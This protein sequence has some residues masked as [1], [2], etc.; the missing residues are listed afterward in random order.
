MGRQTMRITVVGAILIIAGAIVVVLVL[1][2]LLEER[3]PRP[4]QSLV[5]PTAR[6]Q[7]LGV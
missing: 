2:G 3:R 7:T 1:Q 6:R 5:D 4:E